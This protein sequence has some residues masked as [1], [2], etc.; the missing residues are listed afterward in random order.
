[1]I[2]PKLHIEIERWKWNSEYQIYV[3]NLGNF[4]DLNKETVK[5][6]IDQ[7]GYMSVPT[8]N[9]KMLRAHRLVMLTW[10]PIANY[11]Q[12]TVDHLDHN[13]RNNR[14]SNLEWITHEENQLR[15]FKDQ[16]PVQ[17]K[18]KISE[19]T[20][21]HFYLCCNGIYFIDVEDVVNYM[22]TQ[23][24]AGA[25]SLHKQGVTKIFQTLV[26][27]YNNQNPEYVKNG[28]IKKSHKCELSIILKGE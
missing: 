18:V 28:F 10:K 17:K 20:L 22:R 16:V 27:A 23:C 5:P 11:E 19:Y 2:F 9:G 1:M 12:M 13:K 7:K 21:Q 24:S 4:K 26:N 15:A 8:G 14:V 3:S 6:L 25:A